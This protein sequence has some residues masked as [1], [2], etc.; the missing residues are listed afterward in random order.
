[1]ADNPT[2]EPSLAETIAALRARMNRAAAGRDVTL[3]AVSK[4][5]P[6]SLIEQ[7][8]AAGQRVFG[9]NRVQEAAVKFP[10]LRVTHPDLDLH[11]IGPL[12][13]NKARDAV[14]LFDMIETLDRPKL[15]D[16]L[17]AA[18]ER[19]GALPNL[20]VQVNIGDEPQK[21]GI[22]RAEADGFIR[23]MRE[24]FGA[25]LRGL[26]AIPP[27]DADPAP[28]FRDLVAMA[29]HHGLP[30][31]SIGMSEDFEVAIACGATMVRIGSSLFGSRG[32]F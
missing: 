7:A 23:A 22:A 29:D 18:A 26:M 17:A 14:L 21:A 13:T 20:L 10:P 5:K 19:E 3:V 15:A 31:R 6:A 11:L 30:E 8:L 1:M 12:Q 24:R 2:P 4:T 25:N 27:L 9:E 16:A 28:Y 32:N